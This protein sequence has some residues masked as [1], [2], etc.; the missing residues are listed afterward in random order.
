MGTP[1]SALAGSQLGSLSPV[2]SFDL[3]EHN[4]A[5]DNAEVVINAQ[6]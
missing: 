6:W 3:R 2:V 4:T 5:T 1:S